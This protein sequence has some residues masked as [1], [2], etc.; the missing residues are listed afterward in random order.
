MRVEGTARHSR[1]LRSG[2]RQPHSIVYPY[3]GRHR[4]IYPSAAATPREL[5]AAQRS[6]S[7]GVSTASLVDS[8]L[9]LQW[10][11]PK[12]RQSET[13]AR[14]DSARLG[15]GEATT[16]E[17]G[18]MPDRRVAKVAFFPCIDSSRAL[19]SCQQNVK[20]ASQRTVGST[21][22]WHCA[23]LLLL[24]RTAEENCFYLRCR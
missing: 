19:P 11:M 18:G 4:L 8:G 6:A 1:P 13:L 3:C 16:Y 23:G 20:R 22:H 10:Q 24:G 9:G 5:C 21:Q 14:F 12:D 2:R 17:F 7:T 15:D